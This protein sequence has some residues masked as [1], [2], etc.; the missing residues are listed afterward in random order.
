MY[1]DRSEGERGGEGTEAVS[2]CLLSESSG[3]SHT[4]SN[5]VHTLYIVCCLLIV[6]ESRDVSTL[7]P[8]PI[9]R[10]STAVCKTVVRGV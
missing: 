5:R 4:T 1:A 6:G 8:F 10:L 7:I 3:F 9:L 2:G